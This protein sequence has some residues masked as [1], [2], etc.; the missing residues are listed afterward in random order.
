MQI[1]DIM[2]IDDYKLQIEELQ[3]ANAALVSK[4]D[5]LEGENFF[6]L[7]ETVSQ[8]NTCYDQRF[9]ESRTLSSQIR[10]QF[11]KTKELDKQISLKQK[12]LLRMKELYQ[13]MQ[14]SIENYINIP[15]EY[16][17]CNLPEKYITECKH[18]IPTVNIQLSDTDTYS[19]NQLLSEKLQIIDDLFIK[20]SS[21]YNSPADKAIFELV[22][23]SIKT[24][25]NNILFNLEAAQ[26]NESIDL[27]KK[28]CQNNLKLACDANPNQAGNYTK[29]IGELEYHYIEIIQ[30]KYESFSKR[31][32]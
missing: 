16:K 15:L 1:K 5:S 10:E 19:L 4:L 14:Y 12:T 23:N 32:L 7:Q 27:V 17:D 6:S 28:L 22:T 8:L 11:E 26:L 30:V 2:K 3:K 13:A 29:L 9:H 21:Y 31:E 24:D 25:L 18:L 20:Y